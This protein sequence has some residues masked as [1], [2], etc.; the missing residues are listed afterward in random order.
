MHKIWQNGHWPKDWVKS[1]FIPIHKKDSTRKCQNYRTISLS[2]ASKILLRIL[3]QRLRR[4]L[5]CQ[6]PP[7]QAGFD[8]GKETRD[9]IFNIRQLI[10]KARE[11]NTPMLLCF[12]DYRKAFDCVRWS[13]LWMALKEMGVPHHLVALIRNLYQ[14]NEAVVSLDKKCSEV[15]K[16]QKGVRQGCILFPRLFT[17]MESI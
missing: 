2:H 14:E 17:S 13:S 10:E 12:I 15:F 11:F 1:A 6:I 3:D 9:Q 4:Y 8:K 5:D 7:K 16:V